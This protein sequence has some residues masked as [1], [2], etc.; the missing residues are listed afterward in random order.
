MTDLRTQVNYEIVDAYDNIYLDPLIYAIGKF[1]D[2][3]ILTDANVYITKGNKPSTL[4]EISFEVYNT[5]DYWWLI[6]MLNGI[7]NI[8][9]PLQNNTTLYL[10]T[11]NQ[12]NEY[13]SN[14]AEMSSD[15]N[16]NLNPNYIGGTYIM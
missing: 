2:Q 1:V 11:L 4:W 7:D 8:L 9:V 12:I 16:G 13:K 6:G 15:I 5:I 14:I 10:P 3:I